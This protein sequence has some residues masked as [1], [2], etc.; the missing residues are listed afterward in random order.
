MHYLLKR[1]LLSAAI[2]YLFDEQ[3]E[4]QTLHVELTP[5]FSDYGETNHDLTG[6]CSYKFFVEFP[7]PGYRLVGLV[8]PEFPFVNCDDVSDSAIYI[9]TSTGFFQHENG[10]Y[11]SSNQPCDL[12]GSPTLQWDSYFT[13]GAECVNPAIANCDELMVPQNNLC[14]G[15]IDAFE[16]SV[17]PNTDLTDGGSV[18]W[19]SYNVVVQDAPNFNDCIANGGISYSVSSEANQNRILIG[20]FTTDGNISSSFNIAYLNPA[21]EIDTIFGLTYQ[22]CKF[23]FDTVPEALCEPTASGNNELF[24]LTNNTTS[25]VQYALFNNNNTPE[26]TDDVPLEIT[27]AVGQYNS[28]P[29]NPGTYYAIATDETGC[30][31]TSITL[32]LDGPPLY[33]MD[34]I[35]IPALCAIDTNFMYFEY[36]ADHNPESPYN[37]YLIDTQFDAITFND[38]GIDTLLAYPTGFTIETDTNLSLLVIIEDS[39]FC[40]SKLG[41][42]NLIIP[43]EFD[44]SLELDTG[45]CPGELNHISLMASPG[46]SIHYSL[47][48]RDTINQNVADVFVLDT[49]QQNAGE[50]MNI[51]VGSGSYIIYA[52]NPNGCIDSTAVFGFPE[53]DFTISVLATS[54]PICMDTAIGTVIISCS[55]GNGTIEVTMNDSTSWNGQSIGCSQA[56]SGLECG[57]Y[58]IQAT[59]NLGCLIDTLV[60]IPCFDPIPMTANIL[61]DEICYLGYTGSII[62]N[63]N[64]A[65][66]ALNVFLDGNPIACDTIIDSLTCGEYIIR[67]IDQNGCNLYDTVNVSCPQIQ[68]DFT[69]SLEFNGI[70][71]CVEAANGDTIFFNPNSPTINLIKI[72]GVNI[73]QPISLPVD[74]GDHLIEVFQIGGCRRDTTIHIPC[75]EEPELLAHLQ[76]DVYCF[77]DSTGKISVQC[78]NSLFDSITFNSEI[79]LCGDIRDN[80]PCG[81]YDVVGYYAGQCVVNQQVEVAC[82]QLVQYNLSHTDVNC[83]GD[84]DGTIV[85]DIAGGGGRF[86]SEWLKDGD[87]IFEITGQ[88][89]ILV[90]LDSLDGGEYVIYLLDSVL[91]MSGADSACITTDTIN[92]LEPP[93]YAFTQ[94]IV[95]ASCYQLCDGVAL[96][97][98]SGG[99]PFNNP[100]LYDITIEDTSGVLADTNNLC[101]GQYVTTITDANGCVLTDSVEITEPD[102][103]A[104]TLFNR[105]VSCFG[106]CDGSIELTGVSGPYGN[107]TYELDPSSGD[108]DNCSGSQTQ[109]IDVC[110]NDYILLIHDS[111]CVDSIP[112]TIETPAFLNLNLSSTNVTCFGYANGEINLEYSGGTAPVIIQGTTDTL[113]M[114][115]ADLAPE[116]YHY[117]IVDSS[118]CTD[119]DSL[120]ITEPA[121]LE[122]D[123]QAVNGVSCGT[124][125]DGSLVYVPQ[126]GTPPYNYLLLPDS[127]QGSTTGFIP[128]MCAG[129]YTI[130]ITDIQD[131]IDSI[132]FT[133]SAPV[134]LSINSILDQ[135]TCTGM[136]DGSLQLLPSGGVPPLEIDLLNFEYELFPVDSESY[137]I[138]NLGEDS[139]FI[140]LT[141]AVNCKHLDTIAVSPEIITD[142]VLNMFSSRE[143]CWGE[144]NGTATV[145]V[146]NGNEPFTYLWDDPGKQTTSTAVGLGSNQEVT[147]TVTDIIGCQLKASVFVEN[148]DTC[149]VITNALTPNGDGINDFWVLGGL[150]FFTDAKVYVHNRWGQLV[151]SSKGYSEPWDGKS[152]GRALPIGDYYFSIEYAKDKEKITGTVTIK[153]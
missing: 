1:F 148:S 70:P 14:D 119:E 96:Y 149:L 101:A 123:T 82:P 94:S 73:S 92:I 146:I 46:N 136:F 58:F 47:Y 29:L 72:D 41:P 151:F 139:L 99:T 132:N 122:I 42:V 124:V 153:Y 65:D 131:C 36:P 30:K 115:L 108:C 125:C 19:E 69:E 120:L 118:G 59:D 11:V 134:P 83:Y 114:V 76:Y 63:C 100:Q 2:L 9:T 16:N 64:G 142:M 12:S 17:A 95:N 40:R 5:H 87:V 75:I 81:S 61:D 60:S 121:I 34:T 54:A 112:I 84:D 128:D 111:S 20:Q 8:A 48:A 22:K 52:A 103:F 137:A 77:G 133:I 57:E 37:F 7:S 105:R 89:A 80:L 44:M 107:I 27:A 86:F 145:A 6:F 116:M 141:D 56:I 113:P 51:S 79:I 104:Y 144:K 147:V 143:T 97:D 78:N 24:S 45:F 33:S 13:I 98:V 71:I 23:N 90:D 55:G 127:L 126:G 66:Q 62:V 32:T 18:F 109:F 135:P 49:L 43:D 4:A 10:S 85:G 150:E 67:A 31:D 130:I 93:I 28:E 68:Y 102:S 88:D 39:A 38:I 25:A 110:A 26:Y 138:N 3:L 129:D 91:T 35:R 53:N 106:I 117:I 152:N 15:W 50:I 21:N 140:E 74:C